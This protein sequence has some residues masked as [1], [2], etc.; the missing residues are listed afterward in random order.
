MSPDGTPL[1]C[2]PHAGVQF[3]DEG[4]KLL[5]A[6]RMAR[7]ELVIDETVPVD[8]ME[9]R[10][11]ERGVAARKRLQMEI[12]DLGRVCAHGVDHDHRAWSLREPVLVDVR[13]RGRRVGS[14]DNDAR[15]VPHRPG[16]EADQ[17]RAVGVL[18]G[19]VARLVAD[20][21]RIDLGGAEAVEETHRERVAKER[22][23]ARVVG[24]EVRL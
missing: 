7:D 18:E 20:G 8:D 22:E 12:G 16:V 11:G 17:G 24:V 21:L 10:E 19:D 6:D 1:V 3:A 14:S 13:R 4:P 5:P 23:R 15:S 9:E 2:S